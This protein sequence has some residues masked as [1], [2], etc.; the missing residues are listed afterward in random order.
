M[1]CGSVA[2]SV[3]AAWLIAAPM[4]SAAP[5]LRLV[6]AV[7]RGDVP[8]VRTLLQQRADVNAAEPDGSSALHWAAYQDEPEVAALL[9]Q[10]G[11][12][13]DAANAL[14]I[15][16]LKLAATAGDPRVVDLLLKAGANPNAVTG[17]G[18]TILMA[19]ARAGNVD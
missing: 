15:T 18:E 11:A 5:D 2:G 14:G 17:E 10:A 12:K 3:V 9:I 4:A 1:R 6:D 16:P 7:K 8:A 19:A 13:I